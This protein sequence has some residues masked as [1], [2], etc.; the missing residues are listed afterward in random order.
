MGGN[1]KVITFVTLELDSKPSNCTLEK[2]IKSEL[3]ISG[4]SLGVKKKVVLN[5]KGKPN[6]ELKDLIL[7]NY[8]SAEGEG[9]NRVDITSI[10]ELHFSNDKLIKISLSKIE[11]M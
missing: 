8:E 11:S 9:D 3:L 7:Y 10:L 6:K 2:K 4:L 5:L 1:Q